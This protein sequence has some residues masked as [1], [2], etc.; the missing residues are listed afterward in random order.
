MVI[1]DPPA[2][3][4]SRIRATCPH[5]QSGLLNWHSASTWSTGSVPQAGQNATLPENSKV[6]V[7]SS[8][9]EELGYIIVP[10]SSEL[11]FGENSHGITV[12]AIG[13][14]VQGVLR[15]GSDTCLIQTPITIT[16]HGTRPVDAV[17]NPK[18]VTYK[19]IAVTG[20][21]SL[22]GKRYFR[23]WTRLAKAVSPGDS[24]L[25][26]QHPVN[27]EPGQQIV[28]ITT[29]LKDSKEWHQNE[30]LVVKAVHPN[31]PSNV[32]S[33]V[34]LSGQAKYQHVAN[35]GYQAEVGLLSRKIVIQGA[36]NDSE[37]T[38]PDPLNCTGDRWIYGTYEQP[39]SNRALTGFGAHVIVHEG[40]LAFVEGVELY[41]VGQ[42]N[43]LGRYPMHFH[44]L[45]ECPK[46][47]FRYSSVH[48]S[49]YRC[50]SIHGTNSSLVTENVGYDITGY[51][52]YLEDGVE[53]NNTISF[54]LAAFIH[55]I[56]P[57]NPWGWG[58]TTNVYQQSP[59]LTNPADVTA[60]GFYVTN[61]HNNIIGNAASGV[62]DSLVK[63]F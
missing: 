62:S 33:I 32:G 19:G 58:Q 28:L 41:R 2:P 31:P 10:Q 11:I 25:M 6:I 43:V 4:L 1:P 14:D 57:E 39:C 52:Y 18:L 38:D 30:V 44:L 29:A 7:T 15:A 63:H 55:N 9:V 37:P 54:N 17:T 12:D 24:V 3:K 61:V 59:T 35:S 49:Y 50:I 23:T 16:L 26:L 8:V 51:C 53:S 48:R 36:A 40:G 42:T 22:H 46:C 5:L 45:G 56:G 27:W 21:I 13:F 20:T 47:Y 60:A 34:Y